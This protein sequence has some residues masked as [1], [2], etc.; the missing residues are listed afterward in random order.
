MDDLNITQTNVPRIVIVGGGFAGLRLA[1]LLRKGNFQIVLIDKHNYHQFQPLIYQ[2]ATAGLEPS[3]IS[4]PF[5][6]I[7]QKAKNVHF[8]Q[9]EVL[10]INPAMRSIT[11]SFGDL[12]YDRLVIATGAISNFFGNDVVKEHSMV[13]KSVPDS[14]YMRNHLL[15]NFEK[16]VFT[17]DEQEVKSLL[18]VV[19]TGGGPTGVEVA[20][21]IAEMKNRILAKD[22]PDKDFSAM[23]IYLI[24][25]SGRL[26]GT[27]SEKS[28]ARAKKYLENLGVKVLLN[29]KVNGYNGEVVAI[30]GAES[31]P[32]Y[33]FLWT[34]GMKGKFPTGLVEQTITKGN[35]IKVNKYNQVEGYN[36]IYALGDVA[37]ITDDDKYPKGHPQLAQVAIQQAQNLARNIKHAGKP[38]RP[39]VYRDYGIMATM[40]RNAAVVE[41]HWIKFYG[42][43][44]WLVWMFVHLM[45]ILGVKNR[46]MIFINW[47]YH[48]LTF[49]QS[50]RLII[51]QD[52]DKE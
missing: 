4:F 15:R 5:R 28:S 37:C 10:A 16:T 33:N 29:T 46:L 35:R 23:N 45:A 24:E 48:Y 2:V 19:I 31:I 50:L 42:F 36:D 26:L 9:T 13:L 43:F 27:F 7:F 44:A 6:K 21:A 25:A 51:N 32:T 8:R 20:G 1:S 38:L 17:T 52:K 22:Y 34:A 12:S 49:D 11:T 30:D 18:N 47:V 39:F 40:G 3:A 14:L 41:L